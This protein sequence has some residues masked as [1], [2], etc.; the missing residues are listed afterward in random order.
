MFILDKWIIDALWYGKN[1]PIFLFDLCLRKEK[2]KQTMQLIL[3]KCLLG[4]TKVNWL[5]LLLCPCLIF[6]SCP[7]DAFWWCLWCL[8]WFWKSYRKGI[9]PCNL[10]IVSGALLRKITM[11]GFFVQVWKMRSSHKL[12]HARFN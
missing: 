4:D 8:L 5:L 2:W 7:S 3:I 6:V 11:N 9:L 1:N 12:N 10:S